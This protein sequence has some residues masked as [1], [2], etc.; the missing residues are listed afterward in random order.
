MQKALNDHVIHTKGQTNVKLVCLATIKRM[1][2][3]G[4]NSSE[5]KKIL[6][7]KDKNINRAKVIF[8]AKMQKN[9]YPVFDS[10][11]AALLEL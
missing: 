10:Q 6:G 9:E 4:Y 3:L 7:L 8:E 2:N 11:L 1:D 5:V